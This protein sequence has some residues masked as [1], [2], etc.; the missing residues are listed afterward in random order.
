M[1]ILI[2]CLSI[3]WAG[4]IVNTKSLLGGALALAMESSWITSH[5]GLQR[6]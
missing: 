3:K 4:K 5:H 6:S 2:I 1:P